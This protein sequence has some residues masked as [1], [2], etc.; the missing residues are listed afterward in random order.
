MIEILLGAFLF[1]WLLLRVVI[2]EPITVLGIVPNRQR[3]KE[4]LVGLVFMAG[5]AVINFIWQAHLKEISYQINPDYGLVQLLG[6]SLWVLIA[7]ILEELVFRGV[8]LYVLIRHIGLVKACLLSAIIFG[9]YHWFSY[10][11]FGSRLVLMIYVFLITGAGGWM[12]AFAYAKTKSLFA[13][14]GLHLGWNLVTAIV[15]SSG[16][17]GD[18]W[19][20][21]QGEAVQTS[22]WVTLLSFSLQAIFAPGVV[23]WYLQKIYQSRSSS[24][25]GRRLNGA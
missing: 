6:G 4:C 7:V 1:S 3:V 9:V 8:I 2:K 18:Q 20:L 14:M 19:L 13:P 11:V 12:F 17:I 21:E 24:T 5:I 10:G 22:D 16:P 15:F 25:E 23:T